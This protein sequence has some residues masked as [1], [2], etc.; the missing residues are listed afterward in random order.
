MA[1]SITVEDAL[2]LVTSNISLIEQANHKDQVISCCE[3]AKV[4][5]INVDYD[6]ANQPM[7]AK[8]AAAYRKHAEVLEISIHRPPHQEPGAILKS[9]AKSASP[10]LLMVPTATVCFSTAFSGTPI[11][12]PSVH[13][14]SSAN[15]PTTPLLPP[16]S[17]GIT[18]IAVPVPAV[19]FDKDICPPTIEIFPFPRPDCD[20]RDTRQLAVCLALLQA[21]NLPED[22][23]SQ[24]AWTWLGATRP[25]TDEKNR[26]ESLATSVVRTFMRDE[27]KS[28]EV[29]SEVVPLVFILNRGDFRLLLNSFVEAVELSTLLDVHSLDGL[30][31]LIQR[32]SP[33]SINSDDLVNILRV[34]HKRLQATHSQ[35]VSHRYRL[36]LVV[37]RVLDA[38]VDANVGDVD[39]IN[40]HEALTDLLRVSESSKDPYLS[41]EA[42]YATQALLS[43]SDDEGIWQA[44]FRRVWLVMTVGA[45]FAKVP[46]PR[47]VKDALVGMERL[48]EGGKRVTN[49]LRDALEAIKTRGGAEFTVKKGLKFKL[50]WYRALRTAELYIQTGKL[51]Y[52]KDLVTTTRCRDHRMFQLG[53]CQLLGQFA[54]DA[55]WELEARQ[56]AVTFLGALYQANDIWNPQKGVEQVILDMISI[57]AVNP[58]IRF[59]GMLISHAKLASREPHC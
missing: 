22:N 37:S 13:T 38:M 8:L 23:L 31:Q 33:G 15:Q 5:K 57:L 1:P 35:S 20:L 27:L 47:E 41:F 58:V 16:G 6:S 25:N 32:A 36:L 39:R 42:A 11:L 3:I 51:V 48:Y 43:V 17:S 34:L 49:T 7:L 45:A 54:A 50:A 18:G 12:A 14:E 10:A 30:A 21:I 56:S 26:L 4:T 53:I 9:I 19:Y 2:D 28:A 52:F 59:E 29:V 46:D 40:L 44:G 24:E 55:R